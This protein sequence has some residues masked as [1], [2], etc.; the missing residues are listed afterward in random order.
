[1]VFFWWALV[2]FFILIIEHWNLDGTV[3]SEDDFKTVK[4]FLFQTI[5]SKV[6]QI[7]LQ[8]M[9][10]GSNLNFHNILYNF[11]QEYSTW[12]FNIVFETVELFFS[13]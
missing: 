12:G 1:M 2:T 3:K 5:K 11:F 7:P 4:I 13:F 8:V 9:P 10:L 6:S